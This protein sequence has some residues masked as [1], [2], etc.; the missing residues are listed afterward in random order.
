MNNKLWNAS[1]FLAFVKPM[2]IMVL[3][4]IVTI[5]G[6]F[7]LDIVLLIG[8]GLWILYFS[9]SLFCF[10]QMQYWIK[11][12]CDNE[13]FNKLMDELTKDPDNFL[14]SRAEEFQK[15]LEMPSSELLNMSDGQLIYSVCARIENSFSLDE[16]LETNL[17][18]LSPS[19]RSVYVLFLFDSEIKNGGMLQFF[20]NCKREVLHYVPDSFKTVGANEHGAL[21]DEFVE[22]SGFDFQ[23]P[24]DFEKYNFDS[25]N[26]QYYDL[27]SLSEILIS[28]I[29]SNIN[30]F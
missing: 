23:N 17:D 16:A 11:Y 26:S 21:I 3:A 20:L 14:K 29:S 24:A 18:K 15:I 27:P 13:D 28:Y 30:E 2:P 1:L 7:D 4:A 25:F 9:A 10:L 19:Q 12:R 6:L 5:I 8:L 22:S